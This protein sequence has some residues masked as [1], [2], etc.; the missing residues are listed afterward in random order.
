MPETTANMSVLQSAL[1]GFTYK[2]NILLLQK[3]YRGYHNMYLN[4][5]DAE[6]FVC[7]DHMEL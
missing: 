2:Y 4:S 7:H 6:E 5:T 3:F 1:L